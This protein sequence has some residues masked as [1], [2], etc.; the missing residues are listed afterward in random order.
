VI[1]VYREGFIMSI[2]GIVMFVWGFALAIYFLVI[3]LSR[4]ISERI[5]SKMDKLETE[6]RNIEIAIKQGNR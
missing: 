3:G 1:I 2:F 4:L 6:L 5:D